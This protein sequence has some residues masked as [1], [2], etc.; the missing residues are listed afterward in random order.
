MNGSITITIHYKPDKGDPQGEIRKIPFSVKSAAQDAVSRLR[1][2]PDVLR[3][4][5][6]W[7]E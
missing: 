4:D 5:V 1:K 2:S 3:V 7:K 6:P